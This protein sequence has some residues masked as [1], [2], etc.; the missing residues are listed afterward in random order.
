MLEES[1]CWRATPRRPGGRANLL[2]VTS[3]AGKVTLFP[4][5]KFARGA[6]AEELSSDTQFFYSGEFVWVPIFYSVHP[7]KLT[8]NLQI[9]HFQR[10]MIFQT[11]MVIFQGVSSTSISLDRA[12][13]PRRNMLQRRWQRS[14]ASG[15]GGLNEDLAKRRVEDTCPPWQLGQHLWKC[16]YIYIYTFYILYII[17]II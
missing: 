3:R 8:W 9:T 4:S 13:V 14:L 2:D 16:I 7:W 5:R 11:S 15:V 17:Y 12:K 1:H 10:K 6:V